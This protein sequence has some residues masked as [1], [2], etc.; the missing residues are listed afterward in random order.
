MVTGILVSSLGEELLLNQ[1][2]ASEATENVRAT[3]L[4][5]GATGAGTTE[6]LLAD[7][8]SGG[9]AVWGGDVSQCVWCQ[10]VGGMGVLRRTY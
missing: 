3:G 5:V 2:G 10:C 9:L 8:G 6:G 7:Q 1:T 4:V